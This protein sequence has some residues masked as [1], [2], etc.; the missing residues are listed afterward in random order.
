VRFFIGNIDDNFPLNIEPPPTKPIRLTTNPE[1][2]KVFC[3]IS[4]DSIK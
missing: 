4:M 3:G 1:I 2:L